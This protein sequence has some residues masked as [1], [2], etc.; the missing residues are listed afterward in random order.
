MFSV[1][2]PVSPKEN[3]HNL[4]EALKS[5]FEQ[6][7]MS[8]DIVLVKDGIFPSDLDN[9]VDYYS[10]KYPDIMVVVALRHSHRIAGALNAGL[11]KCKN[12][13]IAR[14]DSDDISERDRFENQFIYMEN[15]KEV[16]LVGGHISEFSDENAHFMLRKVPLDYHEIKLAMRKRNPFNH[17]TVMFRKTSLVSVGGYI[18]LDNHVDYFMWIRMALENK[19]MVNLDKVFVK[20]RTGEAQM[21]RRGGFKYLLSEIKFYRAISKLGFL[22]NFQILVNLA[23]RI[24]FR[25][26]PARVR[27]IMYRWLR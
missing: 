19:N 20:V 4:N 25:L 17:V 14:M 26:A 12:N 5:V 18:Q 22:S 13:L 21:H 2:I 7:L 1:L 9:V 8:N 27:V 11:E 6:S 15:H 16:D 10:N 24:P 23:I 3:P